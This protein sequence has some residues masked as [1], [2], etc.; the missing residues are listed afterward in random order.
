MIHINLNQDMNIEQVTYEI[1]L[2]NELI[3]RE[4]VQA[5]EDMLKM[6]LTLKLFLMIV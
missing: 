6:I 1:W 5:P 2:G 3:H 4:Q